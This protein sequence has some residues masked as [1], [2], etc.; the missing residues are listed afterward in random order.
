MLKILIIFFFTEYLVMLSI[1]RRNLEEYYDDI[2]M[3]MDLF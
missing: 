2:E 1:F 3:E